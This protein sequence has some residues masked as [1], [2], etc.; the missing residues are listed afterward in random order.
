MNKA[1]WIISIALLISLFFNF[2]LINL[3]KNDKILAELN[4][5]KSNTIIAGNEAVIEQKQAAI[6]LI[7][8][9]R[10][11]DSLKSQGEKKALNVKIARYE[12]RQ[13]HLP[14]IVPYQ[15]DSAMVDS[16]R[17]AFSLKDSTIDTQNLKIG[18]LERD[19]DA[20]FQSFSREIA[21]TQE[22]RAA[23]VDI[24]N[25]LQNQLVEEQGKTRKE[26]RKKKVWRF[27]AGVGVAAVGVLLLSPK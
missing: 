16:L 11:L 15:P 26:V 10:A 9:E 13:Q 24:S 6:E 23:Q 20:Q 22:Q 17:V 25:Q 18:L 1:L 27:V 7:Q 19:I 8:K 21:Q 2:Y 12:K 5:S 3:R 14:K 4:L